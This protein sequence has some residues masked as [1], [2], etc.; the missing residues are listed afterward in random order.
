MTE[1]NRTVFRSILLVAGITACRFIMALPGL[2]VNFKKQGPL[3]HSVKSVKNDVSIAP[4]SQLS[5]VPIEKLRYEIQQAQKQIIRDLEKDYGRDVYRAIFYEKTCNVSNCNMISRGRTVMA[6]PE[7]PRLVNSSVTDALQPSSSSWK[8]LVRKLA[9]KILQAQY[10]SV[11]TETK[12][13]TKFV[14]ATGGN[15]QAAGHGNFMSEAFTH[16]LTTRITP[17]FHSLGIEFEGRNYGMS[18]SRSAPEV[19][20]CSAEIYGQDVDVL[21]W[22]FGITDGKAS[23]RMGHYFWRGIHAIPNLPIL[24]TLFLGGSSDGTGRKRYLDVVKDLHEKG[25]P[26]LIQN[27]NENAKCH[28]AIPETRGLTD[29]ELKAMPKSTRNFKCAG[30]LES[31]E[32]YCKIDRFN[33]SMCTDRKYM[34]SWH[35]GWKAHALQGNLLATT[36]SDAVED[37]LAYLEKRQEQGDSPLQILQKLQARNQQSFDSVR[38]ASLPML[39]PEWSLPVDVDREWIW[40]QPSVCRTARA[41]AQTRLLGISTHNTSDMKIRS[42]LHGQGEYYH[43][44]TIAEAQNKNWTDDNTILLVQ[45]GLRNLPAMKNC[46]ETW[47]W[48]FYDNYYVHQRMGWKLLVFP[49]EAEKKT[50]LPSEYKLRGIIAICM[51]TCE[52]R[53]CTNDELSFKEKDFIASGLAEMQV[54]GEP[55]TSLTAADDCQFLKHSKGSI[56][57]ASQEGQFEV[58]VRVLEPNSYALLSSIVVW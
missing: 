25:A 26:I 46:S 58:R 16:V 41:P 6:S 10:I 18:G 7:D 50:Y 11:E 4:S 52:V 40:R 35:Q 45:D 39:A 17:M 21:S 48:D 33:K 47:Q 2:R 29:S 3:H 30:F 23:W 19:S 53:R 31:G 34:V 38:N 20:M 15:S 54:N 12:P 51:K 1:G 22:N 42:Y 56:W 44:I 14:W 9:Q 49:N 28:A 57:K 24:M 37:A 5:A 13:K 36:L 43:G 55:V 32:P 8:S 27:E